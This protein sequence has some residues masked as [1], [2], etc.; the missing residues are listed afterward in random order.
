MS[1]FFAVKP[2]P[3]GGPSVTNE[4]TFLAQSNQGF[5]NIKPI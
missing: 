3:A 4:I 1:D 2:A 5:L